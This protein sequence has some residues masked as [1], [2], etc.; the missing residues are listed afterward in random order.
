MTSAI[1]KE[2]GFYLGILPDGMVSC[3]YYLHALVTRCNRLSFATYPFR[4]N[5]IANCTQTQAPLDQMASVRPI[6]AGDP[7]RGALSL[8]TEANIRVGQRVQF[9]HAPGDRQQ[10]GKHLSSK[11]LREGG[12][13]NERPMLVFRTDLDSDALKRVDQL[14]S[15]LNHFVGSSEQ[16]YIVGRP[17]QASWICQVD[18]SQG[19]VLL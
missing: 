6:V 16:G 3:T 7:S 14:P 13:T 9:F 19:D 5:Y 1:T 2:L 17:Q 18:G 10:S 4:S 15:T 12:S 8:D 11:K